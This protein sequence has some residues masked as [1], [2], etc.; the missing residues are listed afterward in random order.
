MEKSYRPRGRVITDNEDKNIAVL[1]AILIIRLEARLRPNIGN[2]LWC[3]STAFRRSATPSQVNRFRW[4]LGHWAH[5]LRLALAHFGRDPRRSESERARRIFVLFC[6]VNNA[7]LYRFPIGQISRNLR[8]RRGSVSWWIL[9]EQNFENFP[10]R[11]R[12]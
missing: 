4:N 2:T 8:T 9:S 3:V 5:C 12:F 11:G 10:V 6:Q 7:R 1:F